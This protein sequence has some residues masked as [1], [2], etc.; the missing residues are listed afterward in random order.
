M[1]RGKYAA[2]AAIKRE[3]AEVSAE[4][5]AYKNAVQRLTAE[6]RDVKD[7]A[8]RERKANRDEIKALRAMVDAGVSLEL[9][10]AHREMQLLRESLDQLKRKDRKRQ[11]VHDLMIRRMA[12]AL[13]AFGMAPAEVADMISFLARNDD[14]LLFV[15]DPSTAGKNTDS[16]A[17]LAS[18]IARGLRPMKRKI[19]DPEWLAAFKNAEVS[20]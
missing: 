5:E 1:A 18:D 15:C 17:L 14:K 13:A 9:R 12:A 19:D 7:R 3:S 8:E 16:R 6:L 11:E 4:I 20:V 10:A 2:K